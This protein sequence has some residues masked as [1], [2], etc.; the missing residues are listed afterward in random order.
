MVK[1]HVYQKEKSLNSISFLYSLKFV[2]RNNYTLMNAINVTQI[3][4]KKR[5]NNC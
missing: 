3:E 2:F 5:K 4:C 1:F